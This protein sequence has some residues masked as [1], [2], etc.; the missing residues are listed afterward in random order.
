MM[1][2]ERDI[3]PVKNIAQIFFHLVTL[4]LF[5]M[6]MKILPTESGIVLR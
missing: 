5:A 1:Y 4:C 6:Q 3:E 2:E